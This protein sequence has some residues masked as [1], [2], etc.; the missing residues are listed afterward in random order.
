MRG[1]LV[2]SFDPAA[3]RIF[4]RARLDPVA[5]VA[6]CER[7]VQAGGEQAVRLGAQD[8]KPAG[9]DPPWR[10]P[11]TRASE[12]VRDRGGRDADPELE[13]LAFERM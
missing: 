4:D 3:G 11:E 9:A 6:V 13:Q 1:G 10:G 5:A 2:V 8:L 12:H 7:R